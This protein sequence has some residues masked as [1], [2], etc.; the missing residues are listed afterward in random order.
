MRP[1]GGRVQYLCL[2]PTR[3]GQGSHAHVWGLVG[4]LQRR[5]WTV[6]VHQPPLETARRGLW[7]RVGPMLAA[8]ASLWRDLRRGDVLYVRMHPLS[9][10]LLWTNVVAG[11][12]RSRARA[13]VEVNGPEDDWIAAWPSLGRVRGLLRLLIRSQLRVADGV[14]VV[15]EGLGH[16]VAG[17]AGAQVE[18]EV[19]PNGVDVTRF[20]AD[21]GAEP[22]GGRPYAVFVGELAP[23]QGVEDLVG[24]FAHDDWP[25]GVDLL[26]AGTGAGEGLLADCPA[27][28]GR[29][30]RHLGA[31]PHADVPSLLAGASVA[32]VTSRDRGGTGIAPLKLF[33][34]LSTG[35]PVVASD[36][37]DIP[38]YHSGPLVRPGDVAGW[39]AAVAAVV[40]GSV[41]TGIAPAADHS[42]DDRARRTERLLG[43]R[44]CPY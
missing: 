4:G 17:M 32:L 39:A 11:L 13:V 29:A 6:T 41:E 20:A 14:V 2:Q 25:D 37:P 40:S 7:G 30:L 38:R 23:W 33:E 35:V 3:E 26:V 31:V 9:A 34:A 43:D 5:G 42:W 44:K 36:V 27:V 10:P 8:Q 1:Q 15:T 21:R 16:W 24:A 12:W 19:V 18:V 28:D 22:P